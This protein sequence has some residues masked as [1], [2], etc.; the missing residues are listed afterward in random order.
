[1]KHAFNLTSQGTVKIKLCSQGT[2]IIYEFEYAKR[3]RS[4]VL[5]IGKSYG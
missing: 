5:N 1:M 2:C 3:F 4:D